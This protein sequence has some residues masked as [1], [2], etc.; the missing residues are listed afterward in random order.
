M[1]YLMKPINEDE[2]DEIAQLIVSFFLIVL[3][4]IVLLLIYFFIEK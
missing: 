4:L 3:L 2:H 1:Q